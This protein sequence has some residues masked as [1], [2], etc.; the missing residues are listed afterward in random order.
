MDLRSFPG[1]STYDAVAFWGTQC[2][3]Y[4][5]LDKTKDFRVS[6]QAFSGNPDVYV[7]PLQPLDWRNYSRAAFNSKDHFWNEE[8]ILEPHVREE[9]KALTG[10]YYICVFGATASNYKISAQ[11]EDHSAMLMAGLSEGGYIE[12]DQVKL[13]YYTDK[14]LMDEKIKIKFDAHVTMGAIRVRSKL[15]R[16]PADMTS[17]SLTCNYTLEELLEYDPEEKVM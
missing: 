1:S 6:L 12:H 13:L 3:N 17:L 7:N 10:V 2:Y 15:C 14:I 8:L 5:V 11:N 4:T 16:R 9:H